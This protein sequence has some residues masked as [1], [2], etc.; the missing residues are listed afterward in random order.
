MLIAPCCWGWLVAQPPSGCGSQESA[1]F[2]AWVLQLLARVAGRQ[3]IAYG[4]CFA[5]WRE[6]IASS[7]YSPQCLSKVCARERGS[8]ILL[9]SCR[10]RALPSLLRCA[11]LQAQAAVSSNYA[12]TTPSAIIYLSFIRALQLKRHFLCGGTI[13][14]Y[15]C[16]QLGYHCED[17]STSLSIAIVSTVSHPE[18][19]GR[20]SLS[21]PTS[22]WSCLKRGAAK[23][24]SLPAWASPPTP[25]SWTSTAHFETTGRIMRASVEQRRVSYSPQWGCPLSLCKWQYSHDSFPPLK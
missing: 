23:E 1:A 22:L 16:S 20:A 25:T 19:Y 13:A 18:V 3:K 8:P 21:R 5:P 6:A 24:E 11:A 14:N 10:I 15:S 17:L 7:P 2:L 9:S 4:W 12:F